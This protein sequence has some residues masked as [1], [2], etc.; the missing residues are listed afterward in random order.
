[1][2]LIMSDEECE[3]LGFQRQTLKS[4][5]DVEPRDMQGR[6]PGGS[7]GV[8]CCMRLLQ[9]ASAY[10]HIILLHCFW[11]FSFPGLQL[12]EPPFDLSFQAER[13]FTRNPRWNKLAVCTQPSVQPR[14]TPRGEGHGERNLCPVLLLGWGDKNWH[15][16]SAAAPSRTIATTSHTSE[17]L[18]SPVVP[19][20][21]LLLDGF[22]WGDCWCGR[23][24][25]KPSMDLG[26]LLRKEGKNITS[27]G[28][29]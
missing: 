27:F 16:K 18:D 20:A 5:V 21:P 3:T 6:Q 11:N 9:R 13:M 25:L 17:W 23:P 14:S 2:N 4:E 15:R 8:C 28:I 10:M 26:L 12:A 24:L 1:M 7:R 19:D 29:A 22:W